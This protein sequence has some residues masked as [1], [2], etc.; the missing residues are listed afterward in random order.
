MSA[1]KR[2]LPKRG[3]GYE[4]RVLKNHTVEVWCTVNEVVEGRLGERLE[5]WDDPKFRRHLSESFAKEVNRA[6]RPRL[7]A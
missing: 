3:I 7:K 4:V 6:L 5:V 1:T 2:E